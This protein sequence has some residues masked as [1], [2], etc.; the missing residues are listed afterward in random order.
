MST[1]QLIDY[2]DCF[3]V[4]D[5]TIQIAPD[6]SYVLGCFRWYMYVQFQINFKQ[7]EKDPSICTVSD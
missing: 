4:K 7:K 2:T 5:E 3:P 6:L 1:N